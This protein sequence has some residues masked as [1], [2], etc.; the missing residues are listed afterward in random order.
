VVPVCHCCDTPGTDPEHDTETTSVRHPSV[1]FPATQ[2]P[3]NPTP[4]QPLRPLSLHKAESKAHFLKTPSGGGF[5]QHSLQRDNQCTKSERGRHFCEALHHLESTAVNLHPMLWEGQCQAAAAKLQAPQ[6]LHTTQGWQQEETRCPRSFVSYCVTPNSSDLFNILY[7]YWLPIPPNP[8][9]PIK[10]ASRADGSSSSQRRCTTLKRSE[11]WKLSE[12]ALRRG[13]TAGHEHSSADAGC[14]PEPNSQGPSPRQSSH[15]G[16]P[17]AAG[18][19]TTG[20]PSRP[21]VGTH[22]STL[23][24]AWYR[25]LQ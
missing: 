23:Q 22:K 10:T 16:V 25:Y 17:G 14:R 9:R 19:C 7:F 11:T 18:T 20:T 2:R 3:P 4:P 13:I 21:G 15:R 1:Q 8:H 6:P 24:E 12:G 5:L